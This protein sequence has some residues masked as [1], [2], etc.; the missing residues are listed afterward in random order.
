MSESAWNADQIKEFIETILDEKDR[1]LQ[2]ADDEREKSAAALRNEQ[3][4]AL[5]QADRERE[6]AA[7]KL[8]SEMSRQIDEGDDRLREH[9]AQQFQQINAALT[10]SEKLEI[11]R[12]ERASQAVD[13]L[14]SLLDEQRHSHEIAQVK[15]ETTVSARF[16]QV[17]EF[18]GSLDDLSK[19][20][21][22]RRE[23]ESVQASIGAKM[24]DL[25]GLVQEL[26]SR[27]DT[28]P[29]GLDELR[30]RADQGQGRQEGA[31]QNQAGLYALI[32][33]VGG[34]LGII[35]VVATVLS[36]Q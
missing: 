12:F 26:R 1:A 34:I 6:R 23:L 2:M 11:E 29:V 8:R 24:D 10:S 7:E 22:T 14:R 21:A 36:N 28:G 13:S 3:Q 19:Q 17:N 31:R 33:A 27:L 30:A 5:D 15:F 16:V 32:G 4:R 20:M 18:R 35:I 9:I 25:A